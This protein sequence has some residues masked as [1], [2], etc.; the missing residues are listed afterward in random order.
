MSKVSGSVSPNEAMSM[1]MMGGGDCYKYEYDHEQ[2]YEFD[3]QSK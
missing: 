1:N 2:V 3:C